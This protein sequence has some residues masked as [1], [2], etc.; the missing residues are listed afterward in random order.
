VEKHQNSKGVTEEVGFR[1]RSGS[2]RVR[3]I[4]GGVAERKEGEQSS[5]FEKNGTRSNH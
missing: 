1:F 4:R 3:T 5:C 2:G